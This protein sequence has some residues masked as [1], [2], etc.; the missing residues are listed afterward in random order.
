MTHFLMRLA[1][2]SLGRAP[3][4]A[5]RVRA[6]YEPEPS[7]PAPVERWSQRAPE[8]PSAS[9]RV[10]AWSARAPAG[11]RAG[12]GEAEAPSTPRLANDR[13]PLARAVAPTGES[14]VLVESEPAPRV[15]EEPLAAALIPGRAEQRSSRPPPAT[16]E[17]A[18]PTPDTR[19]PVPRWGRMLASNAARAPASAPPPRGPLLPA[20]TPPEPLE[21]VLRAS[22]Q[23]ARRAP[24][25]TPSERP[26]QLV[27]TYPRAGVQELA[28]RRAAAPAPSDPSAPPIHVSI[29]RIE[30]SAVSSAPRVKE[31]EKAR[32]RATLEQYL[33]ARRRGA[34]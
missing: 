31:S 12:H 32:P 20:Q 29:G 18:L 15:V 28:P 19:A 25:H 13:T 1:A 6:L 10:E 26:P 21:A 4:L 24:G 16:A 14:D 11:P 22:T 23:S 34:R 2:R 3:V 9:A 30:V 5:P 17:A 33:E 8:A 27:P 7:V